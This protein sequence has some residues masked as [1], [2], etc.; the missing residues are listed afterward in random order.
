MPDRGRLCGLWARH[1]SA[2]HISWPACYQVRKKW[3][4]G[5][6]RP[7]PGGGEASPWE[8]RRWRH[9]PAQRSGAT[10]APAWGQQ[11]HGVARHFLPAH[12]ALHEQHLAGGLHIYEVPRPGLRG[13]CVAEPCA[14]EVP[15]HT[16]RVAIEVHAPPELLQPELHPA[17]HEHASM[18]DVKIRL[19]EDKQYQA[20]LR[21]PHLQ[22]I[23]C[24]ICYRYHCQNQTNIVFSSCHLRYHCFLI[25]FT[26]AFTESNQTP[27]KLVT[28]TSMCTCVMK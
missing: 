17:L 15:R 28:E 19:H 13:P 21:L 10:E 12:V 20:H 8:W 5:R 3:W 26:L 6:P 24:S 1:S 2:C 22:W 7:G 9:P 4:C 23:S 18:V 25:P 11:I 14:P 27:P 16:H